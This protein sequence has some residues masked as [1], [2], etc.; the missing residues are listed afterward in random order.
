MPQN[1]ETLS[2]TNMKD[3]AVIEAVDVEIQR[4]LD[5]IVDPN[6]EPDAKRTVTLT[7]TFKPNRER[8][9]VGIVA[10]AR[11][12]LAPDISIA[13]MALIGVEGGHGVA[14]EVVGRQMEIPMGEN[15]TKFERKANN[16]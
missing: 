6:S 12:S 1:E 13:A 2:L 8:S 11:S 7:I 5:N 9:Q 4:V 10:Q 16:D 15:V 14:N 3:G